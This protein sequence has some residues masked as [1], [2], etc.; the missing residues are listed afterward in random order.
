MLLNKTTVNIAAAIKG[1][2]SRVGKQYSKCSPDKLCNEV[3]ICDRIVKCDDC[4]KIK[5]V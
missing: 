4:K 3:Y 1:T 5:V 2:N